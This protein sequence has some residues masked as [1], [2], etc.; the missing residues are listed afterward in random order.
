MS[1]QKKRDVI[2][3]IADGLVKYA[4]KGV[5]AIVAVINKQRKKATPTESQATKADE[6]STD[7]NDH[8]Q[9]G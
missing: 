9:C 8:P 5:D 1:D 2:D 6:S 4:E 7:E 3:I